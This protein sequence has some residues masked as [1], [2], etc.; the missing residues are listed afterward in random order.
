MNLHA[1]ASPFIQAVN[2]DFIGTIKQST[3]YAQLGD[4]AFTG[5]IAGTTLTV[6]AISAGALVV[7]SIIAGPF[8]NV[9]TT[10]LALGS[11]TGGV[12]TYTV[13]QSQTSASEAMTATGTGKRVPQYS[14]VTNVAM[15]VQALS[16][17]E[18]QHLDGL[19]IESTMRAVYLNGEH[20]GLDRPGVRGGDILLIPTGLASTPPAFDTWLVVQVMESFDASGWCRVAV[21][22]QQAVQS[23]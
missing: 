3:G 10:V 20:E 8:V 9:G 22:L 6:S 14:I 4:A 7:G 5:S 11:G 23:Q 17:A 1:L 16:A 12:G 19:N 2:Q 21:A 15:Q 13:S 18:L